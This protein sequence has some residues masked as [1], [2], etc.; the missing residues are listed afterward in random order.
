[1]TPPLVSIVC[2]CY[3]HERF[4]K[5]AI[6]SA[7]KQS[8]PHVELIV[9]DDCS[10]DRSVARI[11]EALAG[12]PDVE[13]IL[14][15][16]NRGNCRAFN[17]G[18]RKTKGEYIID[19]A[20]DDILM[21]DRVARGVEAFQ[22]HDLKTGVT[23]SDAELINEAGERLGLH[24]DR[25]PHT[26][27]PQG[28]IYKDVLRK[29]FINSPTMMIRRAVL[30]R[31]GG[32]DESLAY[33][34]FDFWIRSSREYQ[35]LYVAEP[36]VKRRMVRG[37]LGKEQFKKGSAQLRSTLSVCG[38]AAMLNRSADEV[39]A[40]RSRISYEIRQCLK[41]REWRLAVAYFMLSRRI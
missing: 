7:L 12:R 32:Y 31:L 41:L 20:A 13:I 8:Y 39:A 26:S 11:R 1:M 10:T 21:P 38:K 36:L 18:F 9:V 14:N 35:Y 16:A 2:L 22:S 27:I 28:D 5:E 23:F 30:E 6:E 24:S 3:N 19:L 29:Y 4:V 37:S 33:E 17:D 25:F 34:D 15:P 40:L